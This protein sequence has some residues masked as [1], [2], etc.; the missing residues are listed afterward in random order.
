[1]ARSRL[2]APYVDEQTIRFNTRELTD[3]QRFKMTLSQIVGQ[4]LT[5][6]E[7]T[8]KFA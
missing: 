5:Y 4:R 1:M 3:L 8:G 2:T 7:L 6:A